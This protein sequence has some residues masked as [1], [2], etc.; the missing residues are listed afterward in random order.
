MQRG[1]R[2]CEFDGPWRLLE[3]R[4]IRFL[5]SEDGM[6]DEGSVPRKKAESTTAIDDNDCA[7]SIVKPRPAASRAVDFQLI[8]I[9]RIR[10]ARPASACW[11]DDR[12]ADVHQVRLRGPQHRTCLIGRRRRQ[13]RSQ[14]AEHPRPCSKAWFFLAKL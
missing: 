11:V 7:P 10:I 4:H 5:V 3:Y 9:A 12:V 13:L 1:A 14:F 2:A 8:G 6:H